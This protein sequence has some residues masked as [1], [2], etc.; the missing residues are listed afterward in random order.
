MSLHLLHLHEPPSPLRIQAERLRE[1]RAVFKRWMHLPDEGGVVP[2]LLAAAVANKLEGEAPVWLMLIGPSGGGKTTLIKSLDWLPQCR[3]LGTPSESGL[4]HWGKDAAGVQ[5]MRGALTDVRSNGY[6]MVPEFSSILNGA[7]RQQPV[8]DAFRMI[9]DGVYSRDICGA[10]SDTR[11]MWEGKCG[12]FGGSAPGID[13]ARHIM[14][15]MGER[16]IYS[17]I[18]YTD[19]D[20]AA[21][22]VLAG[23]RSRQGGLLEMRKELRAATRHV[24]EPVLDTAKPLGL[25]DDESFVLRQ[26]CSFVSRCRSCVERNAWGE[27]EAQEVLDRELSS[28]RLLAEMSALFQGLL[29]IGT[30]YDE[31]WRIMRS[32]MWSSIPIQRAQVLRVLLE[33]TGPDGGWFGGLAEIQDKCRLNNRDGRGSSVNVVSRA[34]ADLCSHGAVE[35]KK[36]NGP[37]KTCYWRV[38]MPVWEIYAQV[39]ENVLDN[40]RLELMWPKRPKREETE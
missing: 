14:D 31:T 21:I 12:F 20:E 26:M 15:K 25:T 13:T 8:L 29:I 30:A 23:R 10:E 1:S 39:Q 16:F 37:R 38:R 27:R 4:L 28:G 36:G 40:P 9:Y 32:I 6:L 11:L 34:L 24:L 3:E 33:N 5:T 35:P 19:D 18:E 7:P 2:L 17:R 22:G